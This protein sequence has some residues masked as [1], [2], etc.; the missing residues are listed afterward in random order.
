MVPEEDIANTSSTP[1][2]RACIAFQVERT[3]ALF[4]EGESLIPALRG[5][6]RLEIQWVVNGGKSALEKIRENEFDVL[7][8]SNN[9]NVKDY[10]RN[11]MTSLRMTLFERGRTE[12]CRTSH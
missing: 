8:K 7:G 1:A 6:L 5:R 10:A 3:A 2:L 4:R 9:L 12:R 11:F